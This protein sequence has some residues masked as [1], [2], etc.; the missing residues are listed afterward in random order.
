MPA[1]KGKPSGRTGETIDDLPVMDSRTFQTE[2]AQDTRLGDAIL[3][4][5][6]V[7]TCCL[8][9]EFLHGAERCKGSPGGRAEER[10]DGDDGDEPH[11][12][13]ASRQ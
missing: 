3:E 1:R 12:L 5:D 2:V 7:A 11:S 10:T 9:R 8:A 6:D 13:D 4:L